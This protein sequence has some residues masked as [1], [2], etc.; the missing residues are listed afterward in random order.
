[1]IIL[2]CFVLEKE[3]GKSFCLFDFCKC[4]DLPLVACEV[5]MNM[6]CVV[7]AVCL[8]YYTS[9]QACHIVMPSFEQLQRFLCNGFKTNELLNLLEHSFYLHSF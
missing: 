2:H 8:V 7:C 1:M 9:L 3:Q 6:P 5:M 4:M